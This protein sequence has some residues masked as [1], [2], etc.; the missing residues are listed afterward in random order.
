[1]G[2]PSLRFFVEVWNRLPMED[3]FDRRDFLKVVGLC[4]ASVA[5]GGYN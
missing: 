4:T 1:M 3:I 2:N 5:F